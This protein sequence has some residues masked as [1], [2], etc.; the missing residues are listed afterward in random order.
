M[1][2][3]S[4]YL[5]T[6]IMILLFTTL[7]IVVPIHLHKMYTRHKFVYD[8]HW[9]PIVLRTLANLVTTFCIMVCCSY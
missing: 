3:F 6:L 1:L 8:T 9:K 4:W 7:Q 2:A 5:V